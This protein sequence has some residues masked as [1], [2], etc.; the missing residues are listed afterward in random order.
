MKNIKP[1]LLLFLV[2]L[3]SHSCI[4]DECPLNDVEVKFDVI[5]KDA[6][7]QKPLANRNIFLMRQL[8]STLTKIIAPNQ[9]DNDGKTR[10]SIRGDFACAQD[11]NVKSFGS[12]DSL[13]IVGTAN[14]ISIRTYPQPPI[15]LLFYRAINTKLRIR[16]E[17][18]LTELYFSTSNRFDKNEP[19]FTRSFQAVQLFDSTFVFLLPINK[20]I[21]LTYAV[22]INNKTTSFSEKIT[23]PAAQKDTFSYEIK[24]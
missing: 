20:E 24:Y 7:T 11:N 13:D 17:N 23:I 1:F 22:S 16:H 8:N 2:A 9:T 19:Y 4:R 3:L 10:M 15:E 12:S 5:A 6:Y 18:P 21:V 14:S